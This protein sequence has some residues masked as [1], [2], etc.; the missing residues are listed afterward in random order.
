[1][2]ISPNADD[3]RGDER[4]E[5]DLINAEFESMVSGLSLDESSPRT[6]LDE[7]DQLEREEAASLNSA[8]AKSTAPDYSLVEPTQIP[9]SKKVDILLQTFK[10]WWHQK[11][12][13]DQDGDADGA[14]V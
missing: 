3:S 13:N 10:R 9:F 8:M 14:I 7:L 12:R 5:M 4:D 11:G 6:Y 1:M 2:T